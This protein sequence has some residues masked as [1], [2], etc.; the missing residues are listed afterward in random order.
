MFGENI[1][2]KDFEIQMIDKNAVNWINAL[3]CSKFYSYFEH[4]VSSQFNILI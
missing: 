3:S 1:S 4:D 2:S